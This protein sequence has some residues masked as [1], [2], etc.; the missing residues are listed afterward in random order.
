MEQ[1]VRSSQSVSNSIPL[2]IRQNI[3][4]AYCVRFSVA[5]EGTNR[6]LGSGNNIHVVVTFEEEDLGIYED[7]VEF[8]FEDV[9]EHSRFMIVRSIRAVVAPPEYNDLLPKVPYFRKQRVTDNSDATVVLGPT[10]FSG[11]IAYTKSLPW[12]AIPRRILD[13]LRNGGPVADIVR[14]LHHS[15][16]PP[17][18]NMSTYAEYFKVL[19]WAEEYRCEYVLVLSLRERR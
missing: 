9:R 6:R 19:L 4:Y 2:T 1:G 13:V 12:A 11:G 8:L 16:L 18:F 17:N 5:I 10:P 14:K 3:N 15:P 7:R